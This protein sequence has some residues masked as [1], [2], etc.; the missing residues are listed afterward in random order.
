MNKEWKVVFP[1]E[2]ELSKAFPFIF[3]FLLP[4]FYPFSLSLS[5][6]EKVSTY[7]CLVP[8]DSFRLESNLLIRSRFKLS[9]NHD[10]T[11]IIE[12]ERKEKKERR[13]KEKR[14]ERRKM[15]RNL[16]FFPHKWMTELTFYLL[17]PSS[18]FIL[19]KFLFHQI[20]FLS[21]CSGRSIVAKK[22]D[23]SQVKESTDSSNTTIED[24]DA[25]G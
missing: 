17:F 7:S 24:E 19:I 2:R 1:F 23:G 13:E 22:S 9:F 15:L 25:K 18:N 5:V 11:L 4:S 21:F 12:G 14:E 10:R 6:R 16:L 8:F 3:L 20:S